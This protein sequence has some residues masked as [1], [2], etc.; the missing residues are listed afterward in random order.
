MHPRADPSLPLQGWTVLSLR[1]RGQHGGLRSAASRVGARTLAL[2]PYA[3][4]TLDDAAT[5]RALQQALGADIIVFTSPNAARSAAALQD[6]ATRRNPVVLAIGSGTRAALQRL[7]IDAAAP[8][9]MDSE[10][11]L[12]MPALADVTHRRI[13]LVTGAGGRNLLAPAL[14]GRGAEVIRA[15]TYRRVPVALTVRTRTQLDRGLA[16]PS[17]LLLVLSS[18]DALDALHAQLSPALRERLSGIA[19]VAAST[20]LA[21]A[22]RA[23][24]FHRIATASSARPSALLRAAVD[25][26]V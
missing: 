5:R 7:G 13:G 1:P 6:L 2:S 25:G 22:A 10:G 18:A 12:A 3:I 17:H 14:R 4:E 8:A 24:G 16:S 15:D 19:V 20:R 26:F 23:A 9:R 11:L 21:G